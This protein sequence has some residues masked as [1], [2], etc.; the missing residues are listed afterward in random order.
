MG[1]EFGYKF[2]STLR[3]ACM[4]RK[5]VNDAQPLIFGAKC[6]RFVGEQRKKN[7]QYDKRAEKKEMRVREHTSEWMRMDVCM[8]E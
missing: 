5:R 1:K 2:I 4:V 6:T 8:S 3:F 7:V